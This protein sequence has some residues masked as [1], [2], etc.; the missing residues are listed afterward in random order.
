MTQL[1]VHPDLSFILDEIQDISDFASGNRFLKSP[2]SSNTWDFEFKDGHNFQIDFD[3]SLIDGSRLIS[4][5]HAKNLASIK[6]W[7]ALQGHP[8]GYSVVSP[9]PL[10]AACNTRKA[11]QLADAL[12]LGPSCFELCR[13]G[14]EN[15][16]ESTLKATLSKIH[17][18]NNTTLSIYELPRRVSEYLRHNI[19]HVSD[20]DILFAR[21]AWPALT[22]IPNRAERILDL[23]DEDLLKARTWLL[24][25]GFYNLHHSSER[26]DYSIR[27]SSKKLFRLVFSD[28]CLGGHLRSLNLKELKIQGYE[29]IS[30]EYPRADTRT[31][32]QSVAGEMTFKKSVSVLRSIKNLQ[33]LGLPTPNSALDSLNHWSIPEELTLKP[34]GRF[35][36]LDFHTGMK[37]FKHAVEFILEYGEPILRSV[38]RLI[39]NNEGSFGRRIIEPEE[40]R[41]ACD[42]KLTAKG[43]CF[44]NLSQT[45]TQTET[46]LELEQRRLYFSM[47]REGFSLYDLV[48]VFYGSSEIVIGT[49]MAR[50]QDEL[51]KLPCNCLDPSSLNLNYQAGKTGIAG[52][53]EPHKRP[54]PNII[55]KIVTLIT[56]FQDRLVHA[57]VLARQ[58]NLFSRPSTELGRFLSPC[59]ASFNG[60]L[61][62]F[63]D[64]FETPLNNDGCRLYIRQHQLR[65]Q[66]AMMFFWG[67]AFGGLDTLRWF[68]SHTDIE[69]LYH[70]I[71]DSIPGSILSSAKASFVASQIIFKPSSFPEIQQVLL[72]HFGTDELAILELDE[73]ESFILE[74]ESSGQVTIE[75]HFFTDSTGKQYKVVVKVTDHVE[76]KI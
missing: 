58:L 31:N 63:C 1:N 22:E 61:D 21:D 5:E 72:D 10:T 74:L 27:I 71:T 37:A 2:H 56:N 16:R 66:F 41:R 42:P 52:V 39:I 32:L 54:C 23:S 6:N 50:R 40:V 7:I 13:L 43:T 75:P 14:F 70:Y 60:A 4:P 64:Y 68:L 67:N 34:I 57:G 28:I 11:I 45:F 8:A 62:S 53:G 18:T 44:W 29:R 65:R 76:A 3:I 19:T 24:I 25:N 59:S 15:I 51:I 26:A 9:A 69:H 30:T 12:I 38:S 20:N 47:I 46:C 17:S 73:L 55:K 35:S 33:Q 49:L 36:T 48:N